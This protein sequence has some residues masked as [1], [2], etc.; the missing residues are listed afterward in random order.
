MDVYLIHQYMFQGSSDVE[1]PVNQLSAGDRRPHM[2]PRVSTT[3][4]GGATVTDTGSNCQP[5]LPSP[6]RTERLISQTIFRHSGR[7]YSADMI[8]SIDLL[9]LPDTARRKSFDSGIQSEYADIDEFSLS[10]K[11]DCNTIPCVQK[12]LNGLKNAKNDA[13]VLHCNIPHFSKEV[14]A[15]ISAQEFNNMMDILNAYHY[16]DDRLKENKCKPDQ[17]C[18]T[19]DI[20]CEDV[21]ALYA[22]VDKT[23]KTPKKPG[24]HKA[25]APDPYPI[26]PPAI[27]PKPKYLSEGFTSKPVGGYTEDSSPELQIMINSLSPVLVRRNNSKRLSR[28]NSSS[29]DTSPDSTPDVSPRDNKSQKS[30]ANNKKSPVESLFMDPKMAQT[31]HGATSANWSNIYGPQMRA[32]M[33][34]LNEMTL[35]AKSSASSSSVE[36]REASYEERSLTLP[37][38][39][40]LDEMHKKL[41]ADQYKNER[42]SQLARSLILFRLKS[43]PVTKPKRSQS[44][45]IRMG[46]GTTYA[47]M[48]ANASS[49]SAS[50]DSSPLV[51]RASERVRIK[52]RPDVQYSPKL[53]R[54]RARTPEPLKLNQKEIQVRLLELSFFDST[55]TTKF[56]RVSVLIYLMKCYKKYLFILRLFQCTI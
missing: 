29:T 49:S 12:G 43:H 2:P 55:V 42:E 41:C 23:T 3:L 47:R 56:C 44:F 52:T 10:S 28:K 30:P 48:A 35:D 7:K 5:P 38:K 34:E 24:F 15:S 18:N 11:S 50:S 6:S 45:N 53:A 40:L 4:P 31:W 54:P 46:M 25:P 16:E 20:T 32:M 8:R 1:A 9:K 22:T 13:K 27:P 37:S 39:S 14:N 51:P 33:K 21:S 19:K 26:T 36:G 17:N